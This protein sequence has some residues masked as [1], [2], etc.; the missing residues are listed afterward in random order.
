MLSQP[1]LDRRHRL[2]EAT[3]AELWYEINR[4]GLDPWVLA[5]TPED[6]IECRNAAGA[7]VLTVWPAARTASWHGH[8]VRLGAKATGCLT[9]FASRPNGVT[10]QYIRAIGWPERKGEPDHAVRRAV[11]SAIYETGLLF[12]GLLVVRRGMCGTY[13]LDLEAPFR[14]RART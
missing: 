8:T 5:C 11:Q 9:A 14:A 4:R 3:D 12:P 13:R 10:T 6:R 1:T 2:R 7:V